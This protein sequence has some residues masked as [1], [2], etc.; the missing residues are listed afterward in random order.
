MTM[1]DESRIMIGWTTVSCL[2]DAKL[3]LRSLLEHKLIACGQING[4]VESH[5]VWKNNLV[6]EEEWRVALKFSCQ[7]TLEIERK[8]AEIHPYE[9]P[10]WIYLEANGSEAYKKWIN[11]I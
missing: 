3:L 6:N 9:V 7:N 5:Y 8:L 4:P 2:E 1:K 10:Q 11:S